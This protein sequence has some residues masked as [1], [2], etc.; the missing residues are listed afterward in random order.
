MLVKY[1]YQIV[2]LTEVKP[3]IE[4]CAREA[5]SCLQLLLP[6]LADFILPVYEESTVISKVL[7]TDV[8]GITAS[9]EENKSNNE[10]LHPSD[11]GC[12]VKSP[13]QIAANLKCSYSTNNSS[14]NH[15]Q[16]P[17]SDYRAG[18][19]NSEISNDLDHTKPGSQAS[20]LP[21]GGSVDVQ[22][23][24]PRKS[25]CKPD[26]LEKET[27]GSGKNESL[28]DSDTDDDAEAIDASEDNLHAHGIPNPSFNIILELPA[29]GPISVQVTTDNRDVVCSLSG[30][31]KLITN[32]Y[33]PQ[34]IK[35]L[36][37][38]S[39]LISEHSSPHQVL[40]IFI[41]YMVT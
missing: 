28:D 4:D 34:V 7:K 9:P 14:E 16:K 18:A 10:E 27:E 17:I 31:I 41:V 20:L 37:V 23:N 5:E 35:W 32:N 6:T 15:N 3:E 11:N 19:N 21:H 29:P 26:V 22:I 24:E 12:C 13:S 1:L 2:F 39:C 36:E 30:A 8:V 33:L 40:S 25:A 38:S